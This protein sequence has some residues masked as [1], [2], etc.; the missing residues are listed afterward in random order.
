MSNRRSLV[1]VGN[2]ASAVAM[3]LDHPDAAGRTALVADG[4][5][6]STAEL[7]RRIG[8]VLGR[9]ARLLAVPPPFLRIAGGLTGKKDE[10]DR[11]LGDFAL[12]PT[13]LASLGWRPPF[14]MDRGLADTAAWYRSLGATEV[15]R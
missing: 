14:T 5:I 15:A 3:A 10:V 6:V 9:P 2:L 4:E 11:L 12:A 8:D 1:Y 13:V 7:V